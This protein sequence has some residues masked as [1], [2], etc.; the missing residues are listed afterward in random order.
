MQTTVAGG[1]ARDRSCHAD[2]L[3]RC[4]RVPEA[5]EAY[6]RTVGLEPDPA[7]WEFLLR[8]AAKLRGGEYLE[9]GVIRPSSS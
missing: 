5:I 8:R 4:G 1:L 3:P 2:L 6:Q 9:D 7:V